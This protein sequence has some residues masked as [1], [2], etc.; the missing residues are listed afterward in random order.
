[1]R[2]EKLVTRKKR[3]E[4]WRWELEYW[5]RFSNEQ[6]ELVRQEEVKRA[7]LFPPHTEIYAGVALNKLFDELRLRPDLPAAGSERVQAEWLAHVHVTVDGR[8]NLGLLKGDR[9]FWPPLLLR[10][11]FDEERK[12]IEQL[13]R[14][15]KELALLRQ[16]RPQNDPGL[17]TDL[18]RRVAACLKRIDDEVRS[19]VEDPAW[20]DRHY[21]DARRTLK[22]VKDA[23]FVLEKPD[24]AY[25]LAPLQGK[26]VA[27]LVAYM[28]KEGVHF[29]PATEGD[30]RHYI[31][32]HRAL[33]DEVTRLKDRQPSANQP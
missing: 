3:I 19:G 32:L 30:G 1:V 20:N 27:E 2:Q 31:A 26:T 25:Y 17:L 28:K 22:Y 33:A 13:L 9:I 23:I 16:S 4:Q 14:Q 18:R 29:A 24:A 6:R 8:G 21:I 11:D 15:A 12:Q 7:L 5:T 10:P